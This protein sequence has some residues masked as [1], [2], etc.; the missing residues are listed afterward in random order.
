[1]RHLRGRLPGPRDCELVLCERRERKGQGKKA[2]SIFSSPLFQNFMSLFFAGA[3]LPLHS[4][5]LFRR[6][7]QP[8][9]HTTPHLHISSSPPP[10]LAMSPGEG[11]DAPRPAVVQVRVGAAKKST[12]GPCPC[13]FLVRRFARQRRRSRNE[14]FASNARQVLAG[15]P[16]SLGSG[17]AKTFSSM[18]AASA[19]SLKEIGTW[20]SE[21]SE[22]APRNIRCS[23]I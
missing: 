22:E 6:R 18:S 19:L 10:P 23:S 9:H 8:H 21:R 1:V 14:T 16:L 5:S 11:D 2:G 3:R 15:W 7:Q 4:F 20:E 17:V 12:K 13:L